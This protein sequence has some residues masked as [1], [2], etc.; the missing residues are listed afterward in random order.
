MSACEIAV[1]LG[2]VARKGKTQIASTSL[3]K[4]RTY[5]APTE[6]VYCSDLYTSIR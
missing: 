4:M 3:G 1:K 6:E 2:E 5:G